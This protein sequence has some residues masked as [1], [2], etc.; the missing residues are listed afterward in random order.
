MDYS[1]SFN[2][3]YGGGTGRSGNNENSDDSNGIPVD[4]D[5]SGGGG[6]NTSTNNGVVVVSSST[7]STA[8]AVAAATVV[9]EDEYIYETEFDD[10]DE[11]LFDFEIERDDH[12]NSCPHIGCKTK[13]LFEEMQQHM[14]ENHQECVARAANT[15]NNNNNNNI[16]QC[17]G[18]RLTRDHQMREKIYSERNYTPDPNSHFYTDYNSEE[19]QSS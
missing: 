16:S 18:C 13:A 1:D 8:T 5:F 19:E 12:I 3:E 11:D 14:L 6:G 10:D 4:M 17:I 15:N 2:L 7:T 9:M